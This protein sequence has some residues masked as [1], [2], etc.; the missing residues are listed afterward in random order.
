MQS[1]GAFGD[2]FSNPVTV[3][4]QPVG[5]S[6]Q[7]DHLRFDPFQLAA[8][9]APDQVFDRVPSNAVGRSVSPGIVMIEYLFA[10]PMTPPCVIESPKKD[11]V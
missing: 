7:H 8:L 5:S 4:P 1:L 11:Q 2:S 3:V 6:Q 10:R 9:K